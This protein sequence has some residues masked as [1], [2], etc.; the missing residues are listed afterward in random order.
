MLYTALDREQIADN[1]HLHR[2]KCFSDYVEFSDDGDVTANNDV[3]MMM[4]VTWDGAM[5]GKSRQQC[6]LSIT[7][8]ITA[9]AARLVGK[10]ANLVY[11]P[12]IYQVSTEY[13]PSI[14]QVDS[15]PQP[16]L[17]DVDRQQPHN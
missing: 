12:S 17:Q 11:L 7:R 16:S 1:L 13:L 6:N 3:M 15:A 9:T 2:A 4:V 14:Y 10:Y 5:L 8:V